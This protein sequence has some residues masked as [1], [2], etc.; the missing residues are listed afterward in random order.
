MAVKILRDLVFLEPL[1]V[2]GLHL[3]V[4]LREEAM[5]FE[6]FM[7]G[8]VWIDIQAPK[9]VLIVSKW[10]SLEERKVWLNS[11]GRQLLYEQLASFLE[12]S[13]Q[14]R[15]FYEGLDV[16]RRAFSRMYLDGQE[17]S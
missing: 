7:S 15:V 10:E 6:G 17:A 11:Q 5:E 14:E 9:R 1:T 8:E 2:E 12:S 16:A 3:L 13:G 4:Q